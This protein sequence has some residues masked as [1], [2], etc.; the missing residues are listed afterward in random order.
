MMYESTDTVSVMEPTVSSVQNGRIVSIS[1]RRA[2]IDIRGIIEEAQVAFSCLVQPLSGDLVICTKTETG[3]YYILGI[4]ER[5]G[6]QNMTLSFPADATLQAKNGD[7]YLYSDTSTTIVA[8]QLNCFSDKAIHK[9]RE[10]IVDYEECTARGNTFQA[11]FK[12]IRLISQ[13]INT[14]AKNIVK[15]VQSYIRHVE[16]CDQVKA[17][18]MTRDVKGLYS[19]DSKHTVMVSKKD[20]KIDGERIHMG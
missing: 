9:C 2:L 8:N 19:V 4:I 13:S 12:T 1:G 20:T 18:Q 6:T 15:R 17:G 14:I 10:A 5:P 16:G 7:F 11:G 3:M